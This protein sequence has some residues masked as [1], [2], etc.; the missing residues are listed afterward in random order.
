MAAEMSAKKGLFQFI[1]SE[2]VFEERVVV[3]PLHSQDAR[4]M[5]LIHEVVVVWLEACVLCY[6]GLGQAA[7]QTS[8]RHKSYVSKTSHS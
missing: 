2:D 8:F 6:K 5:G 4:I 1:N 7:F 3:V